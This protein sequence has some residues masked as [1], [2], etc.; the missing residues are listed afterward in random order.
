VLFY[1]FGLYDRTTN[2]ILHTGVAL[3]QCMIHPDV[4]VTPVQAAIEECIESESF[5][6]LSQYIPEQMTVAE[7]THLIQ[8]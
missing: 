3:D 5:F 6:D 7:C 1:E 2:M 8:D 4:F